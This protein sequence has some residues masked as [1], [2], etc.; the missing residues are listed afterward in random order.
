MPLAIWYTQNAE[1]TFNDVPEN[2]TWH[3]SVELTEDGTA[4]T[5]ED[6]PVYAVNVRFPLNDNYAWLWVSMRIKEC[7][8]E[9]NGD[10]FIR[11]YPSSILY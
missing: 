10:D 11:F 7:F 5:F 4:V 8:Q 6:Q 1:Y 9:H 2:I 3:L